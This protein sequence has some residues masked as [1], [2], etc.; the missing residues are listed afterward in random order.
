VVALAESRWHV[1]VAVQG[2][3]QPLCRRVGDGEET[4]DDR[5]SAH[6]EERR[7]EAE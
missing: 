3:H 5:A 4:C 7:S 2:D 1:K 6:P